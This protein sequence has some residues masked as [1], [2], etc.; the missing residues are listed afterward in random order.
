MSLVKPRIQTSVHYCEATKRG[1][2]KHYTDDNNIADVE[3]EKTGNNAFPTK[4]ANDNPL[5]AE[6]GYCI[7]KDS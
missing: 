6:Y 2:V 1:Q 7:Y 3:E 5:S 4:D